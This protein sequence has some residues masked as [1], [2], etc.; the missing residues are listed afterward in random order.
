MKVFINGIKSLDLEKGNLKKPLIGVDISM[1]QKK[2][3]VRG[4]YH[5]RIS[6]QNDGRVLTIIF[7]WDY[8]KYAVFLFPFYP[9]ITVAQ[10]SKEESYETEA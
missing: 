4:V 6:I 2:L 5:D 8:P 1:E 3:L 10:S 7:G 9:F